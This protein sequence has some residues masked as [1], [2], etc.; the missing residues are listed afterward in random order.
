MGMF[1]PLCAT[2]MLT[3]LLGWSSVASANSIVNCPGT[4]Q[5][6]DREFTLTTDD[7]HP[8]VCY[9]YGT[10]NLNGSGDFINGLGW[11]TID[12]SDDNTTGTHNGWL[13]ILGQGATSGT[14]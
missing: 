4:V 10:G 6:T 14:F 9:Q 12:K 13:T 11:T 2:A 3:L 7:A 8:S 5:T 1:K